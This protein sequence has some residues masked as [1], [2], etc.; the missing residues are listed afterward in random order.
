A[1]VAFYAR[2]HARAEQL[3]DELSERLHGSLLYRS[4]LFRHSFAFYRAR[5]AAVRF[6]ESRRTRDRLEVERYERAAHHPTAARYNRG[7]VRLLCAGVA[8]AD[9]RR[10]DARRVLEEAAL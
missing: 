9:G 6:F 7:F 3:I 4:P 10:R 2:Q 5:S 8:I 1:D